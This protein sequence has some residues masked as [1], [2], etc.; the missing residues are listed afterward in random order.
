MFLKAKKV[1]F[2]GLLLAITVLLVVFSGIIE[3]NTLFLLIAASFLVGI[4]IREAGISL[5]TG[6]Y[7][8]SILLSLTLAPN[9]VYCFTFAALAFYILSREFIF[10][11]L[12][13]SKGKGNKIILF[14]ILKYVVF[15]CIYLSIL[16]LFPKIIY[17]GEI[18]HRIL[19]FF[20][21]GGQIGVFLFDEAY[22]YFQKYIWEKFRGKL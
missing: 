3:F 18:S 5:G 7:I 4:A 13:H 17:G 11:K 16:F 2:L 6:F 12:A 20:I 19:V 1:A 14:W 10:E 21:I 22:N 8:G 9:K 15:N